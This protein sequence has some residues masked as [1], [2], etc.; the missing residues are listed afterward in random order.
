MGPRNGNYPG[1]VDMR[2]KRV[3]R[4]TAVLSVAALAAVACGSSSS[5]SPNAQSS[6]GGN[7]G[8]SGGNRASC[9]STGVTPHSIALGGI[10]ALSTPQAAL[11]KPISQGWKVR[12]QEQNAKGGVNGRKLKLTNVDDG[13]SVEKSVTAANQLLQRDKAFGILMAEP[14]T[15]GSA[16]VFAQHDVPVAGYNVTPEWGKYK[17]MFGYNGSNTVKPKASTTVG[18][19]LKEQGAKK[20]GIIGANVP[21][22]VLAVKQ[23]GASFEAAGGKTVL[24]S[25]SASI[26]NTNWLP[27]AQQFKKKGADA[28]YVPLPVDQTLQILKAL[29]QVGVKPKL[30]LVPQGYGP[31]TLKRLGKAANGLTFLVAWVPYEAR[32]KVPGNGQQKARAAFHKYAPKLPISDASIA[33]YLSGNMMIKGLKLA[34]KDCPTR[35]A[36]IS[37]LRNVTSYTAHGFFNPPINI[38][39]VF[40]Q[41]YGRCLHFV[42]VKNQKY[43]PQTNGK[44]ICGKVIK[45]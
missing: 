35:K 8:K 13:A 1:A 10:A 21:A 2:T 43:V 31:A 7:G 4:Y 17:N 26:T 16:P 18:E 30:T 11:F 20:L 27:Q 41:E 34:G 29:H 40:G 45:K 36:F 5:S 32:N 28:L 33:G 9:D 15:S 12:I 42:T 25:T 39:T 37:N 19:F 3:A 23:N 6:S 24:E 44:A 14:L 22:A 38:K